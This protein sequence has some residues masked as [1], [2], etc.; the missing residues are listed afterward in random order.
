MESESFAWLQLTLLLMASVASYF[1][2]VK[3]RQP[4]LIG[5]ILVGIAVSVIGA[6]FLGVEIIPHHLVSLL[7]EL[8]AIVLL[9]TIGLEVDLRKIYT[10]RNILIAAGGVFVPLVMG[11]FVYRAVVP[12]STT[13]EAMFV[14]VI[15]VATSV[16][17]AADILVEM[18]IYP[19][20]GMD[21]GAVVG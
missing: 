18:K 17:V 4:L 19:T 2:M 16:A 21:V 7:A 3:A 9:F 5:E 13:L 11:F 8:G 6:S 14:G 1:I 12:G 20:G 15:L 10:E